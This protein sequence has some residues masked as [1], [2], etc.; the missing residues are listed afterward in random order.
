MLQSKRRRRQGR[1]NSS[2]FYQILSRWCCLICFDLKVGTLERWN[3]LLEVMIGVHGCWSLLQSRLDNI[4]MYLWESRTGMNIYYAIG[5]NV[6][7]LCIGWFLRGEGCWTKAILTVVRPV[8]QLIECTTEYSSLEKGGGGHD[9]TRQLSRTASPER[10]HM[11]YEETVSKS[12]RI[13][14]KWRTQ[15]GGN[16]FCDLWVKPL[17]S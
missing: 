6:L 8:R 2:V 14:Q 4:Y 16:I 1:Q 9:H 15:G 5:Y 7:L 10:Q 3:R 11:H 17:A 13:M 12:L